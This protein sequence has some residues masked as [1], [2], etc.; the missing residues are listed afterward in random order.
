MNFTH[1]F[2]QYQLKE[3]KST[4]SP[5]KVIEIVQSIYQIEITTPKLKEKITKT[6]VLTE[7]Q[8]Q[9]SMLFDFGC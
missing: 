6:L 1:F 5:E 8:K 7:E 9:I 3:K 4:V 2:I